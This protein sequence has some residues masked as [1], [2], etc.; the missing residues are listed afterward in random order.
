MRI[1]IR[2]D[3]SSVIGTGHVMRCLALAE[4]LRAGGD[5][6]AFICRAL[7][8]N[9]IER[10]RDRRFEVH[11][12]LPTSTPSSGYAPWLPA[13]SHWLGASWEDDAD[14]VRRIVEKIQVGGV[15]GLIVDHYG[16]DAAWECRVRSLTGWLAVI[17]DLADRPHE[18]DI[19]LDQNLHAAP[20]YRYRGLVPQECR[21][22]LGPSYALLRE[23]FAKARLRFGRNTDSIR[24][25]LVYFGGNDSAGNTLKALEALGMAGYGELPV[26]VVIHADHTGRSGIES[27]C[28][29]L[30]AATLHTHV[31]IMSDLMIKAD[32]AIGAGGTT[33]WERCCLGLPCL[34]VCVAENQA[35]VLDSL[36]GAGAL[37]RIGRSGEVTV[38]SM[39]ESLRNL[40]ARPDTLRRMSV[41]A[42]SLVDGEGAPRVV[43]AI[44]ETGPR[45]PSAA[46]RGGYLRSSRPGDAALYFE[47]TNDP[48]TRRN[49]FNPSM[50]EWSEH[51]EWFRSKLADPAVRMYVLEVDGC[52]VGEIRFNLAGPRA[53]ISF[54]VAAP[55]R[56][57]GFGTSL[58]KMGSAAL[59]AEAGEIEVCI[60]LVK[61]MNGASAKAF[62]KAG[63]EQLANETNSGEEYFVFR[64]PIANP[65]DSEALNE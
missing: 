8:G 6:V 34:A 28:G 49:S 54:S 2:T 62:L 60:G 25:I 51:R 40:A 17:D 63:F 35:E 14:A 1:L 7:R 44:R 13:H 41:A 31:E 59:Q 12:L 22:L 46:H 61:M 32:L 64:K 55:F 50:V 39:A 42:M 48:G 5:E 10:I 20:E 27:H 37:V 21:L 65:A 43:A 38:G 18:C 56:G 3:A 57:R 29:S 24:R 30:K 4:V 9:L 11:V 23:E 16:L 52:P 45:K 58:L 19:L 15:D 47:W 36:Q 26:D 53:E 33:S